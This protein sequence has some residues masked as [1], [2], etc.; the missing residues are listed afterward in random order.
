MVTFNSEYENKTVY[1]NFP[2][3]KNLEID[4]DM[5]V[6]TW[7]TPLDGP[8]H[9]V[10]DHFDFQIDTR[11]IVNK[12]GYMDYDVKWAEIYFGDSYANHD[13]WFTELIIN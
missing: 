13:N 8:V 9:L 7:I 1:I 3:F 4:A 6:N 5:A 10:F 12:K 11:L 2:A